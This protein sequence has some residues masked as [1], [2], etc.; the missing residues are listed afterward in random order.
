MWSSVTIP[1]KPSILVVDASRNLE[2][3]E[4]EFMDRL[5]SSLKR[6]RLLLVGD[7]PVRIEETHELKPHLSTGFNCILFFSHGEGEKV[8]PDAKMRTH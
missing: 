1:G 6:S 4:Y 3:W 8:L 2:G 5:F 7:T